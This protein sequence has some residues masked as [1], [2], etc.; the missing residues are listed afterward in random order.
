LRTSIAKA[1]AQHALSLELR[2][3]MT[4]ARFLREDGESVEARQCVA[5]VYDRFTEGFDTLDLKLAHAMISQD[6]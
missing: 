4:L 6:A 2:S 3:A 5:G 1:Q